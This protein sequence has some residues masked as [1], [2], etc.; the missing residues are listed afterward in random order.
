MRPGGERRGQRAREEQS[1]DKWL[2]LRAGVSFTGSDDVCNYVQVPL[3]VL[4]AQV[5]KRDAK[6]YTIISM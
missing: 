4:A 6:K 3:Q 1:G 2:F 5:L